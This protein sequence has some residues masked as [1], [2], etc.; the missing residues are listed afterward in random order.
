MGN[1]RPPLSLI[2][3]ADDYGAGVNVNDGVV[4][5]HR[6]GVVTSASLMAG[7]AGFEDAVRRL[8]DF[9]AL[10]VGVHLT[11]CAGP[12]V[13]NKGRA[14]TLIGEGGRLPADAAAFGGRFIRGAIRLEDIRAELEA[15][16]G[17]VRDAGIN[18]T[19][20]D[21]H[22]HLHNL[23]GVADVVIALA[24]RFG[25][26]AVRASRCRVWPPGRGWFARQLLLRVN[27]EAFMATARRAGLKTPD[28]LL[29]QGEVG[30]LT[31]ASILRDVTAIPAGVWELL[32]HPAT[33]NEPEDDAAMDRGGE[34]ATLTDEALREGL[35]ERGVRL[36]NFAAL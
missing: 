2:I 18:I 21:S 17:R 10:G 31:P 33:A 1:G 24:R 15:Q 4:L 13:L 19:H 11:L 16:V 20:F 23:P 30:R 6:D 8:D 32:C 12:P 26:R 3:N 28:G 34:L 25:V 7:G 9:P 35:R 22:Q 5:A 27:A 29:G 14:P 36:L